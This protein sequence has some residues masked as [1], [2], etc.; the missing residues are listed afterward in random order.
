MTG[1]YT[2]FN[3]RQAKQLAPGAHLTIPDCPGLR[4]EATQTTKAWTYRYRALADGKLRQVKLG[5]WPE[6]SSMEAAD[7]WEKARAARNAGQEVIAEHQQQ[8][9]AEQA[10]AKAEKTAKTSRAYTVRKLVDAY[11]DGYVDVN[12]KA[13]GAA[14]VRRMFDTMLDVIENKP[15]AD[16]TRRDAFALLESFKHIPVQAAKLRQ[17]LGAAWDRA[18]DAGELPEDASNHWRSIMRGKLLSKGK[19]IGGKAVGTDKRVLK[20]TEV[21]ELVRWLPNFSRIVCDA[22][23]LYLWTGARGAEIVAM[24]AR[25]I[26]EE[27]DGLWWTVPKAKTKNARRKGAS[28]LR[29]P[30]IGRAE[31]VVRRL[32]EVNPKGYLFKS[33]SAAGHIEQKALGVAAWYHM[34]YSTTRPDAER[35]RLTVTHWAPHD[36]RRTTRTVL[37]ALG[38]PQ[39]VAEAVLG[40]MPPGIIGVYNLHR[41]DAE[42]RQWL[43]V[44][45]DHYEQLADLQAAA[46]LKLAA[47]R[48]TRQPRGQASRPAGRLARVV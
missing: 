27:T 8:K 28:D 25:E 14:E 22:L 15:A 18:L 26:S 7:A 4:L 17:E 24:E 42:R 30:L 6:M 1:G 35:P 40:H 9:A 46:S 41:Y 43:K 11:L 5:L 36:L 12:R 16:V 47:T 3:S 21:G 37:S 29:V 33:R 13:R 10:S 44:L 39:D 20:E 34:P 38:C 48:T 31:V 45:A 23:T 19:Q 2:V 32:L